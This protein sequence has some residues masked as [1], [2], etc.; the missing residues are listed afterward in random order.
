MA[1]CLEKDL[2]AVFFFLV[3]G[4]PVRS[5]F[6]GVQAYISKRK[7]SCKNDSLCSSIKLKRVTSFHC[8]TFRIPST[9]KEHLRRY[10]A[11][12]CFSKIVKGAMLLIKQ[13]GLFF[14]PKASQCVK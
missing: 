4:S 2:N 13:D 5:L 9:G 14:G 10:L 7:G 8:L 1:N 6:H 12:L 11:E 3:H